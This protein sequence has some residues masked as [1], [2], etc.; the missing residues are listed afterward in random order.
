MANLNALPEGV[1]SVDL[2]GGGP[3]RVTV[4]LDPKLSPA[5]NAQRYFEKAR[6]S[7]TAYNESRTRLVGTRGSLLLVENL[8][9]AASAIQRPEDLTRF[10]SDH[11]EE[12]EKVGLGEKAK[13][14]EQLPFRIFTVDGG[15]E[16]WAGKNGRNND[17]LTL[18]HTKPNDLWFHARGGSGSHVVL[19]T[20]TGKG[21]VS[22]KAKEQAAGIAAYYSKMRN[23]KVGPVA[24]TERKYVRKPK[25][26]SPGTVILERENVVF[27]EPALPRQGLTIVNNAL[28]HSS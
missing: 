11:A 23:A 16:V 7:R 5:Q 2:N 24:M 4:P 20:G 15:Y 19:K 21:E 14:R 17:E 13:K 12:L 1:A 3:S 8:I 27:A 26:V 28:G 9:T 25:G 6:K 18:K 10:L 22:K